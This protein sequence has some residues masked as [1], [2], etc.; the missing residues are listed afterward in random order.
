M[1]TI[2]LHKESGKKYILLGTSYSV[3]KDSQ[4]SFMGGA[5]FPHEEE[6]LFRM[7]ALCDR[8]GEVQWISTDDIRVVEV[9]GRNLDE[10][11]ETDIYTAKSSSR[12]YEERYDICPGC[13]T[14]VA[15]NDRECP[16]C[17]LKLIDSFCD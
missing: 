17:G 11:L 10:L 3:Y 8:S 1:A 2:V 13:G 9:D 7:A 5:L 6:G 4:P 12:T 15:I 14:T 16:S